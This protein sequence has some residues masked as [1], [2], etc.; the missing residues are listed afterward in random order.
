MMSHP[1]EPRRTPNP[2]HDG[3]W[4]METCVI[5]YSCGEQ[6]ETAGQSW[7]QFGE[8]APDQTNAF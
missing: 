4:V 2:T 6:S 1:C 8:C 3:K 7:P 5:S